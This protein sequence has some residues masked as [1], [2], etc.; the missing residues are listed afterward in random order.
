MAVQSTGCGHV[1]S[2]CGDG[3]SKHQTVEIDLITNLTHMHTHT[4][5]VPAVLA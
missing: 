5:Q 3:E 1:D 4:E 2:M